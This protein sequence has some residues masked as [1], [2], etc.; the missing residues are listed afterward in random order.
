MTLGSTTQEVDVNVDALPYF[1]APS[2]SLELGQSSGKYAKRQFGGFTSAVG[3][4]R[5]QSTGVPGL[6][7]LEEQREDYDEEAGEEGRAK[8]DS[9]VVTPL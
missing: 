6:V 2:C 1:N 9:I 5:E 8:A 4:P 3:F 7:L